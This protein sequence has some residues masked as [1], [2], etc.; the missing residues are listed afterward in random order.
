[1][2]ADRM[3]AAGRFTPVLARVI[4]LGRGPPGLVRWVQEQLERPAA[5][6]PAARASAIL[7]LAGELSRLLRRAG[8]G[9]TLAA[10]SRRTL[11]G[12]AVANAKRYPE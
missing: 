11:P 6:P 8:A 3:P 1:M 7:R 12:L 2:N 10:Y 9:A 4:E 5:A